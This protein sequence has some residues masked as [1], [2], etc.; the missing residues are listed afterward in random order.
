MSE[1]AGDLDFGPDQILKRD[2]SRE[3]LRLHRV[4]S[5]ADQ[6]SRYLYEVAVQ[7]RQRGS[8]DVETVYAGVQTSDLVTY[9]AA[10]DSAL[11]MFPA[12]AHPQLVVLGGRSDG[13]VRAR[14]LAYIDRHDRRRV[15]ELK[16][17][18]AA[19][20]T[21]RP[22]GRAAAEV[23]VRRALTRERSARKHAVVGDTWDIAAGCSQ[24]HGNRRHSL[25]ECDRTQGTQNFRSPH[26][27]RRRDA[28]PPASRRQG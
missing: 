17:P 6:G 10:L 27:A 8:N 3:D 9:G 7:V 22:P 21:R 16:T 24:R 12:E 18:K 1:D 5:G 14:A 2:D 13:R 19:G 11:A 4:E 15:Q 20:D 26:K 25:S 23:S 28:K